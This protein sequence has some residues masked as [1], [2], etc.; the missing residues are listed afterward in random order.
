LHTDAVQT[1][2]KV[3]TLVDE[4]G[5]EFLTLSAHKIN[6]PKG[7]GALYWRGGTRWTPLIYGGDQER[8]LRAGTEG[9]H[10][11]AGLG[12]AAELAAGRMEREFERLAALRARLLEGL[13]RVCPGVVVNEA[14]AGSQM[15]GTVSATFPGVSGLHLLA[16]LDCYGVAVSIG[17]ACTADRVEPSHVLLGMGRSEA[18]ALST[19]R[20]SMGAATNAAD[21]K[22]FLWA[23]RRVEKGP[24]SG[25]AYLDPQHLTAERILSDKTVVVDLRFPYERMLAPSIP[26]ARLWSHIGF[27]RHIRQVPRDK[28]VILMCSTG[29]FS[30]GAGYRL[31]RAGHP[32]VKVVYGGYA[33]WRALH[34]DLM[35]R[36]QA[37]GDPGRRTPAP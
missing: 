27:E 31:A 10:Q 16:G 35:A 9:T 22:Y 4:L 2:G 5:C 20:I 26:G 17:S 32:C 23:L 33:A 1:F 7:V 29:I 24:P 30:L 28:E 11:I 8:K 18:E 25:F 13:G 36:L 6:G 3:Q 14:P 21:V 34:P 37:A 12:A 15:P 19:I